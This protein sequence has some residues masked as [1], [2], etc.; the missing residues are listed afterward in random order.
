MGIFDRF[1]YGKAGKRDY[2]EADMPKTRLSLFFLVLKDHVFDLVKINFLQLIFYVPMFIWTYLN[3]AAIQSID[4]DTVGA[5]ESTRTMYGYLTMWLIGLIPCILITGP[6]NAGSAYVMRNW[7]KD[8]HSFLFSD[9]KDAF[10]SNWKQAL[11]ASGLTAIVPAFAY[12]AITYY[13]QMAEVNR[14]MLVPLAVVLMI[15]FIYCLMQPLVYPLI[16]GYELSFMNVLRNSFLI[17]IAALPLCLLMR[18]LTFLPGFLLFFGVLTGNGIMILVMIFY[19]ML[20]GLALSNLIIAS[21]ANALFDKYL[22]PHI[23]GA[24]VNVGLRP[25]DYDELEDED[26][27]EEDEEADTE[28]PVKPVKEKE[29]PKAFPFFPKKR[30]EEDDDE[31]DDDDDE[32]DDE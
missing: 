31:D 4:I 1:Y 28:K 8:Q 23:E 21:F 26:D 27:D 20:F 24:A 17:T 5:A 30:A 13:S 10:K 16:I 19:F 9:F 14:L 25:A 7:A 22:N 32:E 3:I 29:S 15:V 12:I 6:A 11:L 18:I 2:T